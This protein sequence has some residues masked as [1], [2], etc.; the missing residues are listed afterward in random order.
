[1]KQ[2]RSR[3]QAGRQG[4]AV[5]LLLVGILKDGDAPSHSPYE[6]HGRAGRMDDSVYRVWGLLRVDLGREGTSMQSNPALLML[7]ESMHAF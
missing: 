3:R 5:W 4:L 6:S 1:M 7:V 2:L